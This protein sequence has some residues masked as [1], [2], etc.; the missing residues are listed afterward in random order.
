MKKLVLI[1]DDPFFRVMIADLLTLEGFDVT[2]AVDTSQ[3]LQRA[4][5]V[6][7]D[8]ILYHAKLPFFDADAI[9]AQI[10]S[11]GSI[12]H[13]PFLLLDAKGYLDNHGCAASLNGGHEGVAPTYG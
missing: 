11:N 2:T 1:E 12:A 13:I 8:F 4:L 9:L 5:V 7:P 6:Q 3:G 10:R